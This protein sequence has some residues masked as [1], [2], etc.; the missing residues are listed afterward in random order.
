MLCHLA[1]LSI[2]LKILLPKIRKLCGLAVPLNPPKGAQ[3]AR[4]N[5]IAY[6]LIQRQA[7][8]S[9]QLITFMQIE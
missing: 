5:K 6:P 9:P 4:I 1:D 8:N 2:W 3:Y 7:N